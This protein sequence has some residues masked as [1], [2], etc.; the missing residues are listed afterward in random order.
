[1]LQTGPD[2]CR[3]LRD[4]WGGNP[5]QKPNLKKPSKVERARYRLEGAV[6]RLEEVAGQRW[7]A[8]AAS[9]D[10]SSAVTASEFEALR[11]ENARLRAL[12]ETASQHL[13]AAIGRLRAVIEE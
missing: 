10:E 13:D 8:P 3:R 9:E 1:M 5:V 2:R 7:E 4:P 11:D 12:N 6:T